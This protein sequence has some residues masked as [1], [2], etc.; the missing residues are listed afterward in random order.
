M[1]HLIFQ[2]LVENAIRHG[3]GKHPGT[4]EVLIRVKKIDHSLQLEVINFNSVLVF[5]KN[6]TLC[7]GVA[8]SNVQARLRELYDDRYSLRLTPLQPRGVSV[9]INLPLRTITGGVESIAGFF[10]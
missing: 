10:L 2:P 3:I 1:P 8:L 5:S 6:E 9:C 7:Q 4:D